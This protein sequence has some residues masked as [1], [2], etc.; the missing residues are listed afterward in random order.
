M[1]SAKSNSGKTPPKSQAADDL[2]ALF[3]DELK[4]LTLLAKINPKQDSYYNNLF[5]KLTDSLYNNERAIRNK[6]ARIEF[7]TEEIGAKEMEQFLGALKRII[8]QGIDWLF[9]LVTFVWNWSFGQISR[10]LNL[11]I[12]TLPD[13]KALLYILLVVLLLYMAYMVIPRILAAIVGIFGAI[14][15]LVETLIKIAVDMVWYI[16]AAYGIAL[17]INTVKVGTI[18]GKLP[19][20]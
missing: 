3:E 6:F 13:W 15:S 16:L 18:F 10:A 8:I 9:W 19:L 20:Q 1:A 12:Q 5:I 4:S 14:W 11:S 17:V 2:R 7:E